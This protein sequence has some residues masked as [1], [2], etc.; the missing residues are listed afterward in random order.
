M[1]VSSQKMKSRIRLSAST[2]PSMA[3]VNAMSVAK[4]CPRRGLA[5]MYEPAY[6]ITNEP[7]KRIKS[8]KQYAKP[9]SRRTTFASSWGA[10]A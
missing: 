2:S 3:V 10:N 7:T 5:A 8:V 6:S 1:L 9:S 4:N